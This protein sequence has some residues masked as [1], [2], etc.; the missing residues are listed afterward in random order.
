MPWQMHVH[1]YR[2]QSPWSPWRHASVHGPRPQA[3]PTIRARRAGWRRQATAIW[4]GCPQIQQHMS[5]LDEVAGVCSPACSLVQKVS[6]CGWDAI[7]GA[8]LRAAWSRT[9]RR[10]GTCS[11]GV[12]SRAPSWARCARQLAAPALRCH[13]RAGEPR[14]FHRLGA[15]SG[16]VPSGYLASSRARAR[17]TAVVPVRT[18]GPT[19]INQHLKELD[20]SLLRTGRG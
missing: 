19:N 6:S 4:P 17:A 10:P 8:R 18:V 2:P 15:C 11:G 9:L 20:R 1:Q 3:S 7:T 14:R 12:P 16:G 13:L 5:G